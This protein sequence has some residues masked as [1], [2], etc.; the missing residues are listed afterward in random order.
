MKTLRDYTAVITDLTE[1][2]ETTRGVSQQTFKIDLQ[3]LHGPFPELQAL[4]QWVDEQPAPL[5]RHQ[6]YAIQDDLMNQL[7][8]LYKAQK[9]KSYPFT[10]RIWEDF[11]NRDAESKGEFRDLVLTKG[12][13]SGVG[14]YQL[15]EV[16]PS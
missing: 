12:S 5:L 16:N 7:Y 2:I 3:L 4:K 11:M 10:V 15:E 6:L 14:Q 1:M 9:R 8:Q 13:L